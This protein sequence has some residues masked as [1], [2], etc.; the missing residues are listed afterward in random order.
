[1]AIIIKKFGGTSLSDLDHIKNAA[2]R[3]KEAVE[4]GS[5]PV[6]VVS[7]MGGVTGQLLGNLKH[8][9]LGA[10]PAE[11]DVVLSAGEQVSAGTFALALRGMGLKARSFMGW[12]VPIITSDRAGEAQIREIPPET[13]KKSIKYGE[14]P[15]IAG[16]QGVTEAGRI[17]T[18]GRGGSDITAVAL[19]AALKAER[20][21]IYTDVP[22]I[23]T[24]DPNLVSTAYKLDTISYQEVLELAAVGA[25]VM[26]SRAVALALRFGVTIQVLTSYEN[27]PG[28]LIVKEKDLTERRIISGIACSDNEAKISIIGIRDEPGAVAAIFKPLAEAGIS[29]DMIVQ[30]VSKDGGLADVTFT[31][32]KD[33]LDR[34]LKLIKGSREKT[35]FKDL[36]S[37]RNVIKLTV[38]GLGMAGQAGVAQTMFTALG[39]RGINIQA[40]SATD[41][42]ISVLVQEKHQKEALKSL[43]A[44]YG[45]D[46]R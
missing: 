24:A 12:Q 1:M 17:T 46:K 26:H 29:V 37:D 28:T 6:V 41:I 35:G 11:S 22:G 2:L 42:K 3:V 7:A 19:A 32:D 31:V 34:T 36:I 30:D 4:A 33:L 44:A 40:I 43:H 25:R 10:D 45:L 13:L 21:D 39:E 8:Q 9:N 38:V 16:F 14:I 23:Y 18:L 5:R 20:C 15:V 27:R